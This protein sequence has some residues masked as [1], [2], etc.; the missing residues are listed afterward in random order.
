MQILSSDPVT[1]NSS[2]DNANTSPLQSMSQPEH[3]PAGSSSPPSSNPNNITN[4]PNEP[5]T[6]PITQET[7]QMPR[8]PGREVV[9]TAET[10][11]N[12]ITSVTPPQKELVTKTPINPPQSLSRSFPSS[13]GYLSNRWN[14]GSA[15]ATPST[16]GRPG[17]DSFKFVLPRPLAR[18][19]PM[20]TRNPDL[21]PSL[22]LPALPPLCFP[23]QVLSPPSLLSSAFPSPWKARQRL[24]PQSRHL[25]GSPLRLH[26][27]TCGPF[28]VPTCSVATALRHL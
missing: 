14:S 28:A 9:E 19:A 4:S 27:S 18:G 11:V 1:Y 22:P 23:R 17:D 10:N 5:E 3:V 2:F 7:P 25:H 26:T 12:Q 16:L 20:L 13:V 15:F 8:A 24:S 21:N 6:R